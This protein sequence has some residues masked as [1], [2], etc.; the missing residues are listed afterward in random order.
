MYCHLHRGDWSFHL[1]NQK[2]KKIQSVIS[3][4]HFF[5]VYISNFLTAFPKYV[6]S[7]MHAYDF[8]VWSSEESTATAVILSKPSTLSANGQ[9]SWLYISAK[10]RLSQH[11]SLFASMDKV[12]ARLAALERHQPSLELRWVQDRL[13]DPTLKLLKQEPTGGF[14]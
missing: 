11:F 8:T 4:T 5:L 1:T 13:E 3:T 12:S 10:P 14:H 7:T 6:F 9:T 2:K